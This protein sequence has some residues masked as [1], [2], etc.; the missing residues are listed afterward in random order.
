M[1]RR[2]RQPRVPEYGRSGHMMTLRRGE[3]R[4]HLRRRQR[5][6][7]LTFAPQ[8]QSTLLA[9]GFGPL[10]V[11][12]EGRVPPQTSHRK[13]VPEEA[14]IITYVREGTLAYEDSTGRSGLLVAGEFQRMTAG[15]GIRYGETNT[16]PTEWA[17]VFQLWLRPSVVGLEPGHEQRLFSIA[18]RRGLLRVVASPDGQNGSLLIHQDALLFSTILDR[19]Q[20]VVHELSEGRCAWLH[21]V[22]G[23]VRCGAVTMGTGDGAGI[24]AEPGVS[25]TASEETEVLLLDVAKTTSRA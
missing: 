22:Q 20:H 2:Q 25:L 14:E 3:E 1:A 10:T 21:I 17:H 13:P 24:E 23:T 12:E 9:V 5:E 7:W 16:S 4:K 15:R 18:E 11:F 8:D 6:A 19:G